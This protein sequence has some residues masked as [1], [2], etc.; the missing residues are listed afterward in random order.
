[1]HLFDL[2]IY[3]KKID[4]F[5]NDTVQKGSLTRGRLTTGT[6]FLLLFFSLVFLVL[7][8]AFLISESISFSGF[9][10]FTNHDL[11]FSLLCS[12]SV[13]L[14]HNLLMHKVW[15][16]TTERLVSFE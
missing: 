4:I 15:L 5:P 2:L 14:D 11:I 16:K 9:S 1:M 3:M 8:L 10:L 6:P 7:N 12:K 13:S